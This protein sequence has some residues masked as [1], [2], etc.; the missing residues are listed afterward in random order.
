MAMTVVAPSKSVNRSGLTEL[1]RFIY[2][3]GR[4]QAILQCDDA[5]AITAVRRAASQDIGG[6]TG[7]LAPTGSSQS[8]GSVERWHQKTFQPR[9]NTATRPSQQTSNL[10]DRTTNHTSLRAMDCQTCHMATQSISNAR[11]RTV[12]VST[13]I[14]TTRHARHCGV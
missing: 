7:R 8:Q 4:T 1:K 13:P 3:T 9:K 5:D 6:L 11:R 2:E 12:F 14:Q 10:I